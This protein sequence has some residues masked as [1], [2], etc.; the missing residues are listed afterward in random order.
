MCVVRGI[1]R[2]AT[3]KGKNQG[4]LKNFLHSEPEYPIIG[5]LHLKK[6]HK[7]LILALKGKRRGFPKRILFSG[8]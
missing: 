1:A 2:L 4:F 6:F 3:E 5:Q 7:T 8:F